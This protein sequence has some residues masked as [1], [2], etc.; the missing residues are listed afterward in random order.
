VADRE[1]LRR[2]DALGLVADIE[3]HL[4]AID[5]DDRA[6]DDVSVLE[7]PEAS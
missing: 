2:D 4:V 6:L 7:V 1:L 3:Q 5:L